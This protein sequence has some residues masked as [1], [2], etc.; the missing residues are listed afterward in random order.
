MRVS[1]GIR[2]VL[3][4]GLRTVLQTGVRMGLAAALLALAAVPAAADLAEYGSNVT[5]KA[6]TGL[7]GIVTFPADPVMATTSP[8][9]EFS[10]M[11]GGVALQYPMGLM[12]GAVLGAWRAA[13]GAWD[14]AFC[15][16]TSMEPVS[17]EPRYDVFALN[18]DAD[19]F[20]RHPGQVRVGPNR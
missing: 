14:L 7:N 13:S 17:P 16:F 3:Q 10:E 11:P 6:R 12:Q 5:A 15:W 8:R 4:T 18:D 9:K 1:V 2:T 19:E 20:R